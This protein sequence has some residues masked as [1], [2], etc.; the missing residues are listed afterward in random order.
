M[1]ARQARGETIVVTDGS[2]EFGRLQSTPGIVVGSCTQ[3]A[4]TICMS[5]VSSPRLIQSAKVM[6]GVQRGEYSTEQHYIYPG[7]RREIS[8]CGWWGLVT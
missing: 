1:S 2:R 4:E 6:D 3:P 5:G 7:L 8:D